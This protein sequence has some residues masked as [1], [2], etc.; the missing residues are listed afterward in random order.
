MVATMPLGYFVGLTKP[1]DTSLTVRGGAD[2]VE[3]ELPREHPRDGVLDRGQVGRPGAVDWKLPRAT[4]ANV[5][6]LNPA[7][8]AP[9][10]GR[11]MPPA[12]PS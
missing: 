10:T 5:F 12:R 9:S 3:A 6:S 8:C 7:V 4:T 11:S 1:A 2:P